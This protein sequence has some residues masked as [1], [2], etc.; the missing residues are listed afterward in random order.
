MTRHISEL[1]GSQRVL[2]LQ[3]PM[4]DF[5]ALFATWLKS[6]DIDVFKI[7]FNGGDHY[8]Y[9][10]QSNVFDYTGYLDDFA[11]W[12]KNFL[13]KHQIDAVVCFGDCRKYHRIAKKVLA[14]TSI[15]F[16]AFE[17]GYIRPDYITFEKDGVNSFSNFNYLNHHQHITVQPL[18]LEQQVVHH[19]YSKMVCSAILY[20]C[21][22]VL[23]WARYRYYQHHR[24]LSAWQELGY[25]LI[26][27]WR[28]QKNALFE[29]HRFQAFIQQY[30]KQYYV[31]TLQVHNDSQIRVHSRLGS[32]EK[33]IEQVIE[34]FSLYASAEQHLLFKHHPMDRGYRH[35]AVLL[36]QLSKRFGV[37][38][39]IHY[40]CDIHL[41]TLFK[42]SLGMVTVNS[43]TVIQALYHQIPVKILG[44]ALY[45]IPGLSYQG[46]LDQFWQNPGEVDHAY[47]LE[48]RQKL[49]AYSQL[50][51]SFYGASP[52]MQHY[53]QKIKVS[54][55]QKNPSKTI[56]KLY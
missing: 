26:S 46:S 6:H 28:R 56:Y 16:F 52:W 44:E 47:F 30:H 38:G 36:Q 27:M 54:F 51:G 55:S 50:N 37:T 14:Q 13:S 20:Y 34:S 33:Y 5:F 39:R 31:F 49:I 1:L 23:G 53:Y 21:F 41:P 25:A 7:N 35:Y 15:Q 10:H 32:V 4:G 17:E 43:T 19:R 40:F 11:V 29:P 42:H 22:T 8:F 12:L 48:F 18:L 3:G 9:R 45:N 2:L 24:G